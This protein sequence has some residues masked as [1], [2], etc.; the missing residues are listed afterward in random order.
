MRAVTGRTKLRGDEL[1]D[2]Y[3]KTLAKDFKGRFPSFKDVYSKLSEA[4][5]R[6]ELNESLFRSELERVQLHFNGLELF[7][8]GQK[9]ATNRVSRKIRR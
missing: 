6:A 4:L 3:N 5:H 8:K 2:E 9:L 7:T 1:C